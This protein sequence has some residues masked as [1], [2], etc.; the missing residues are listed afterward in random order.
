MVSHVHTRG[1]TLATAGADG[2]LRAWSLADMTLRFSVHAHEN[3]VTDLQLY[4]QYI[5]T[6]GSDGCVKLWNLE[7]GQLLR[8]LGDPA[9]AVWKVAFGQ[10]NS[11]IVA[12]RRDT[13]ANLELYRFEN[14][15]VS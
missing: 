4:E 9:K 7:T 1:D 10:Q 15:Y 5:V 8:G 11:I 2:L 6:G 12:L 13:G 14:G 3:S